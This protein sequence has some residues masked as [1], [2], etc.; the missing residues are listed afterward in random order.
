M[1]APPVADAAGGC[2]GRNREYHEAP[3]TEAVPS[4]TCGD[5]SPHCGESPSE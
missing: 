3:L 5:I 1:P 2:A 4:V